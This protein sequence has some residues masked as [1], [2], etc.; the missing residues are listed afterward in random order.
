MPHP[1]LFK[2]HFEL[3]PIEK[4]TNQDIWNVD[5]E[6]L[7][8]DI[9]KNGLKEPL[10]VTSNNDGTYRLVEGIHRIKALRELGWKL[11]PAMVFDEY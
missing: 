4:I 9:R 3:I 6:K 11:V 10:W 7:K 2:W 5:C 8:E 1:P